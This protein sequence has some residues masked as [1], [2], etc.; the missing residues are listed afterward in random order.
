[1]KELNKIVPGK[2]KEL[3]NTQ[4]EAQKVA[5]EYQEVTQNL[6]VCRKRGSAM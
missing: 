2:E 5:Q 1:M 4:K 3:H 6:Q